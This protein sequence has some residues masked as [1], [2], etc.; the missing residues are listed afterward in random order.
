MQSDKKEIY[1]YTDLKEYRKSKGI[2]IEEIIDNTKINKTYIDAIENGKFDVLPKAYLKLFIKTYATYIGLD[3]DDV[4]K[5]YKNYISGDHSQSKQKNTPNFIANKHGIKDTNNVS[6]QPSNNTYFITTKKIS[7]III[8]TLIL[9]S[10]LYTINYFMPYYIPDNWHSD[11]N[12]ISEFVID[13]SYFDLRSELLGET[14]LIQIEYLDTDNEFLIYHLDPNIY[15]LDFYKKNKINS[16]DKK[17]ATYELGTLKDI[18]FMFRFYNGNV[19][20]HING[21][22]ILLNDN[23]MIDGQYKNGEINIKYCKFPK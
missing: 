5:S 16:L 2:S 14:I 4:L 20:F 1:F 18:E 11:K 9:L 22:P 3:K 12:F 19:L 23:G 17:N 7:I 15:D 6:I 10:I 13:E 8:T 21:H